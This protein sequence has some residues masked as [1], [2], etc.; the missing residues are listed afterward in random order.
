MAQTGSTK[1]VITAGIPSVNETGAVKWQ[2]TAG[3]PSAWTA[4]VPP[5]PPTPPPEV[6]TRRVVQSHIGIHISL[7]SFRWWVKNLFGLKPAIIYIVSIFF[8]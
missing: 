8:L 4:A 7:G 6:A 1:W 5:E 2:I 3:I